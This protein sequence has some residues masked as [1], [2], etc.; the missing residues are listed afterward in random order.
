MPFSVAVIIDSAAAAKIKNLSN[1][2]LLATFPD[3]CHVTEAPPHLT[4]AIADEVNAFSVEQLLTELAEQTPAITVRFGSFG[5]FPGEERILFLAP[6][7]TAELMSLHDHFHRA[8]ESL[9]RR[10][11]DLYLPNNWVPH[12]TI[13]S[14]LSQTTFVRA[15]EA[16][17]N[18]EFPREARLTHIALTEFYEDGNGTIEQGKI[19]VVLPFAGAQTN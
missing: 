5:V 8:F 16:C 6:V 4:F 1:R 11:Y 19:R 9:A 13:A 18:G 3:S 2:V 7:V 17:L 10:Q 12:C 15:A 14:E